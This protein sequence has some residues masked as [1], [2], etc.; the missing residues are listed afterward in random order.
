MKSHAIAAELRK[1]ADS[2]EKMPDVDMPS[3]RIFMSADDKTCFLNAVA[4]MP[5]PL[6]KSVFMPNSNYP[7]ML[8]EYEN[9][10]FFITAMVAQSLTCTL[11]EPAKPA[12]YKC[13]PILSA[14]EESELVEE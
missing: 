14:D 8:L 7:K 2:I 11:I 13:E 3:T 1:L 12:V 6:K 4:R 9:S 5:R 10:G